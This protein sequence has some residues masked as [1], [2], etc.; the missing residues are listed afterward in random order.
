MF[1]DTLYVTC[2]NYENMHFVGT[3]RALPSYCHAKTCQSGFVIFSNTEVNL[4]ELEVS[5]IGTSKL[6]DSITHVFLHF[7]CNTKICIF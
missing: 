7:T 1:V 4:S 2:N 3:D 6:Y 5:F